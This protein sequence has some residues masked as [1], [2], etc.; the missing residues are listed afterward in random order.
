[1]LQTKD[2]MKTIA[3]LKFVGL[4]VADKIEKARFIML[5]M[6]DNK[7]FPAPTPTLETVTGLINDLEAAQLAA[8]DGNKKD[9][10]IKYIR[11]EALSMAL[12]TLAAYV[13][14]VAN[15]NPTE[16]EAIV[17]S[18]GMHVKHRKAAA[19]KGFEARSTGKPGEVVV[20]T[21]CVARAS[22]E[23]QWSVD[24]SVEANWTTIQASTRSRLIQKGLPSGM[25]YYYRVRLT[26]PEGLQPWSEVKSAVVL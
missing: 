4:S 2:A 14:S 21:P 7:H 8:V 25:R 9:T 13:E 5:N 23:F 26:T 15:A 20:R 12:K 1:L 17:L 22:Y 19:L 16:A 3:A 18:S 6:K 10:E 24:P 11:A